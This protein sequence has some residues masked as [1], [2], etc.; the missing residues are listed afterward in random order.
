MLYNALWKNNFKSLRRGQVEL[1]HFL[2]A[3]WNDQKSLKHMYNSIIYKE[4]EKKQISDWLFWKVENLT[5][6]AKG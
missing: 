1:G 5:Q 6:E 4:Q 2:L 3:K